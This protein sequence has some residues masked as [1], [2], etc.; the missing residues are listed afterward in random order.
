[1]ALQIIGVFVDQ[2]PE[3][4]IEIKKKGIEES[5]VITLDNLGPK[6]LSI[7]FHEKATMILMEGL[8]YKNISEESEF[9]PLE[10]DLVK[11]FPNARIIIA[12]QNESIDFYGYS[13]LVDSIKI[14]TKA[15]VKG[16]LFLDYGDFLPLEKAIFNIFKKQIEESKPHF[17]KLEAAFSNLSGL[18][19]DKAYMR[20]HDKLKSKSKLKYL[21]GTMD[22]QII[23]STIKDI[24]GLDFF[25]IETNVRFVQFDKSKVNFTKESLAD[26]LTVSL[27]KVS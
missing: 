21:D 18:E 27:S 10:K 15:V 1:M 8:Y 14:R 17:D 3:R 9:T 2:L 20:T 5:K 4:I 12:V 13:L 25:E 16:D 26:Y 11:N 19:K 24:V 6:K 23:E 22:S 7:G